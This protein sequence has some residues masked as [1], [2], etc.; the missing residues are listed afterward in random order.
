MIFFGH[1]KYFVTLRFL[2]QNRFNEKIDPTFK[3][4]HDAFLSE[5]PKFLKVFPDN[6]NL[7]TVKAIEKKSSVLSLALD[8]KKLDEFKPAKVEKPNR[9]VI[10]WNHRWEYDKNPDRFFN[11]LFELDEHGIDFRLVVLGE[12]YEKRPPVFEGR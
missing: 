7:E 6:N 10:L 5:L 8:L 4:H 12:S 9:A 1:L 2:K 3:Y 11:A